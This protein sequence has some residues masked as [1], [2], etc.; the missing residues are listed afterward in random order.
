MCHDKV[1]QCFLVNITT[2]K[3]KIAIFTAKAQFLTSSSRACTISYTNWHAR[4]PSSFYIVPFNAG[5]CK[6]QVNWLRT[7]V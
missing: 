7:A 5:K 6:N 1:V 2:D 4:I 3:Q